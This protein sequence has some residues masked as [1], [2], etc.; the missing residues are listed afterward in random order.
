MRWGKARRGTPGERQSGGGTRGNQVIVASAERRREVF[1][2]AS[3]EKEEEQPRTPPV[4]GLLS[5]LPGSDFPSPPP[6][7][8]LPRLEP[9]AFAEPGRG[10]GG[11]NPP[12]CMAGRRRC[13]ENPGWR[14][15]GEWGG[16]MGGHQS[17]PEESGMRNRDQLGEKGL[18]ASMPP[19][20]GSP[21]QRAQMKGMI[22]RVALSNA[23]HASLGQLLGR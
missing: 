10:E 2:S 4:P 5:L 7:L 23:M 18:G 22:G 12:L 16:W 20:P 19:Y 9:S 15:G 8:Q 17:P 3:P 21:N 6:L 14:P 11:G 13:I 1:R